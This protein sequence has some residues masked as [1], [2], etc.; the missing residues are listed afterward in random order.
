MATSKCKAETIKACSEGAM[1]YG[2]HSTDPQPSGVPS[3]HNYSKSLGTLPSSFQGFNPAQLS[4][5]PANDLAVQ[6]K[7]MEILQMLWQQ[8]SLANGG[9]SPQH[10]T[11]QDGIF[12]T[13]DSTVQPKSYDKGG[14]SVVI[15]NGILC[16]GNE[17]R[18]IVM[19]KT[20]TQF[21]ISIANDNDFGELNAHVDINNLFS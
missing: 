8:L 9:L 20:G 14:Y 13:T 15:S 1:E 19:M 16:D 10:P 11:F 4:S 12:P 2:F 3:H 6:G 18:G 17:E 5:G 21:H 7:Q